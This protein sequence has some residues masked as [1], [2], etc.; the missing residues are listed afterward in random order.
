MDDTPD[1]QDSEAE[2]NPRWVTPGTPPDADSITTQAEQRMGMGLHGVWTATAFLPPRG[3]TPDDLFAARHVFTGNETYCFVLR[4]RHVPTLGSLRTAAIFVD[5]ACSHNG[6][7]GRRG[8]IP[9]GGCGFITNLSPNGRHA[10][11]LE[12]EGPSGGLYTHTSNR[13]ELRAAVAALQFRYWAGGGW[14]RIVLITDSQYVGR[15]ATH[16]LREWAQRGWWSYTS[17][18]PIKNR[19]LWEALSEEMGMLARQ[20]CEVSFWVVPRWWNAVADAAAKS[21]AREVGSEKFL[22]AFWPK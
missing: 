13:A 2:D 4:R 5:G 7:G 8:I 6:G 15:H 11:A 16:W 17:N 20:G 10:F 3:A 18:Q 9:R 21:A 22:R 12:Q 1:D 14:E 19:D